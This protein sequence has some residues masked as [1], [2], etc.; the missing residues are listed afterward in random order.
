MIAA[1]TLVVA[2]YDDAIAFYVGTLGFVLVEDTT[3][4]EGKRW[5]VVAPADGGVSL[6]LAKAD[7]DRQAERVGDQTGGRVAFFLHTRDFAADHR[8]MVAAGVHFVEEPRQEPYGIVA[9][10]ED[11]YGNRWDLLQPTAP[12]QPAEWL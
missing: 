12:D 2:D 7:G 9:V 1:V 4:G 10:F 11:V 3:L 6:L 5:V 8:R